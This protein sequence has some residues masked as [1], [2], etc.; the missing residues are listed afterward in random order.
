LHTPNR[1][2]DRPLP[3]SGR[4]PS[5]S[6]ENGRGEVALSNSSTEYALGWET[7]NVGS[8]RLGSGGNSDTSV[9]GSDLPV[10]GLIGVARHQVEQQVVRSRVGVVGA[11]EIRVAIGASGLGPEGLWVPAVGLL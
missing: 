8:A 5:L 10:V 7:P 2:V 3:T 1:A 9:S 6:S 11:V 4:H